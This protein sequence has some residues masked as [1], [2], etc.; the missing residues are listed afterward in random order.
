MKF[1]TDFVTNS[2]SSSFII[3][4]RYLDDDQIEAIYN[5]L[6]L[7][8]KMGHQ[9]TPFDF[10]WN[11]SENNEFISGYVSMDNFSMY[12]FLESIDVPMHH[13]SWSEYEFD[14]NEI[15]SKEINN[16]KDLDNQEWRK[17]LHEI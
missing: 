13:V 5:H 11:I 12:S 17:L 16:T 1:R 15:E 14:L 3:A 6:E 7:Y 9:L 8:Q 2:S 10:S 4:K